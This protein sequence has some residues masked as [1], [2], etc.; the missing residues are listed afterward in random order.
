VR[1]FKALAKLANVAAKTNPIFGVDWPR[2]ARLMDALGVT[3]D[4]YGKK[5]MVLALA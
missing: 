4:R 2:D 3:N 1:P 5:T